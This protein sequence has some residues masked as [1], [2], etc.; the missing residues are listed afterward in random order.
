MK[1]TQLPARRGRPK[2]PGKRAAILDAAKELFARG[3]LAG[4]S[5]EAIAARAGVSKLTLYS[6]FKRKEEL[7]QQA[8]IAKCEEHAP[9]SLYEVKPGEPLRARLITLASGFLALIMSDESMEL[10]RMMAAQAGGGS[11]LGRLFFA[12]GPQRVMAQFSRLL[13]AATRSGELKV[14]DP[15]RAAAHF[16]CLLKGTDHL[17]VLVGAGAPPS[18]AAARAHVADVVELFLR[19]YAPRRG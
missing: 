17:R 1:T 16:F 15:Q 2:D 9:P 12:A 3:G 14:P 10:H 4:T 7:F 19:A 11:K 18:R 5:M 8:V 6:H 13:E